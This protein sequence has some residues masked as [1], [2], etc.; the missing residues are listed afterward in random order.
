MQ[1]KTTNLY[2]LTVSVGQES[3]HRLRVCHEFAVKWSAGAVW[4][5]GVSASKIFYGDAG[6]R[7][8]FLVM[9]PFTGLPRSK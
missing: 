8:P 2:D 7:I 4:R 5:A 3:R 9:K 1:L 6:R